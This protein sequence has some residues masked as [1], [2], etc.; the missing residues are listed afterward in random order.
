MAPSPVNDTSTSTSWTSPGAGITGGY[1]GHSETLRILIALFSGLAIYNSLELLS[2]LFLTFN[3]Y[4][5]LYFWS[6]FWAGVGIIPYALGFMLK[7]LNVLNG[8]LRWIA[9]T[10]LTV[11]WYPM[12]TGQALVLWSRLHLIVRG[13]RGDQVLFWTKCMIIMNVFILHIPTTVLTYGSN[14]DIHTNIFATGYSIMEKIQMIGFFLQETILSLIYIV[15]TIKIL[16]TSLQ[17]GTRRTMKQL[18]IINA[19]IICMD[20][21]LLGLEC[22][23]LYILETLL[24][25]IVYS[26][27]LKLEYA[28]LGK[29][30]NFVGGRPG[31]EFR[32]TSI[33]FEPTDSGEKRASREN[34]DMSVNDFVDLSRIRTD[35]THPT[36]QPSTSSNSRRRSSRVASC[37]FQYDLARFQHVEDISTLHEGGSTSSSRSPPQAR[38]RTA[39]SA[40]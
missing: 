38:A 28:I 39:N 20:L 13:E 4:A 2:M 10:L 31:D 9:V 26:I 1:N 36:S 11:G 12:I 7:F 32:K 29:L 19:V 33:G 15:E 25:G 16:R 21:G 34:W 30:V 23:S 14:G 17:Q 27:K 5:G 40:V 35:V 24:K 3:R 22:A 18:V 6:M 37:D 8:R